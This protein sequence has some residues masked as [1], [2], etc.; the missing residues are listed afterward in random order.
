MLPAPLI[1]CRPSSG[2]ISTVVWILDNAP[3]EA[4]AINADAAETLFGPSNIKQRSN[5]PKEHWIK[6]LLIG[7]RTTRRRW[8]V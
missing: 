6:I 2:V 5:S 3:P 1:A 7:L 8:A 4:A